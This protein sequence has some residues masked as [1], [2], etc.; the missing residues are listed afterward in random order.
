MS[1]FWNKPRSLRD[2]ADDLVDQLPDD[3]IGGDNV[4]PFSNA[5]AG[6]SAAPNPAVSNDAPM[7]EITIK[8]FP[9]TGDDATDRNIARLHPAIRNDVADFLN[10]VKDKTGQQL[11]I[12]NT[13]GFRTLKEQG[14]LYAQGQG[15]DGVTRA[16]PGESYH[17]YGLG[18]D[19]VGL[20]PDGKNVTYNVPFSDIAEIGRDHGFEWGGN[21][22]SFTD[23][24]H[25]QRTYGYTT[26]QL[27]NMIGP[28]SNYP[29]IPADR[30]RGVP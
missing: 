29:E 17:N 13:A 30:L 20:Q 5:N 21:W 7:E 22:K 19:I 15:P 8:S 12:G 14:D 10:D 1:D 3:E 11:R 16:G 23:R 9:T 2:I 26:K 25:F 4:V 27:Q 28:D 18:F 24:P 6:S